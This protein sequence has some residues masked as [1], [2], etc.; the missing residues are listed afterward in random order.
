MGA[1]ILNY[2]REGWKILL[3]INTLAYMPTLSVTKSKV[4]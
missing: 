1:P 3:G 2:I 4:S